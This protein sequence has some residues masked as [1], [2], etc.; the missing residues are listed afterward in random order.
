MGA[1]RPAQTH[2]MGRRE[3]PGPREGRHCVSCKEPGPRM[4]T[5]IFYREELPPRLGSQLQEGERELQ[6]M[7]WGPCGC[8]PLN[9]EGPAPGPPCPSQHQPPPNTTVPSIDRVLAPL[10][11]VFPQQKSSLSS[12]TQLN[13]P[14]SWKHPDSRGASSTHF[15][16]YI[17]QDEHVRCGVSHLSIPASV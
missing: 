6:V 12:K 3:R 17:R 1:T 4:F 13:G 16:W 7:I 8:L 14:C 9:R 15:P 2:L 11:T 5:L 10:N